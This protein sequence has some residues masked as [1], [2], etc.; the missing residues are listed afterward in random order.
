MHIESTLEE[1]IPEHAQFKVTVQEG[2]AL[3]A[4]LRHT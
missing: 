3:D 1:H 4:L 2:K